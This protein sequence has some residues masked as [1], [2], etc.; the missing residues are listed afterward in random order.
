MQFSD[1][2]NFR[3]NVLLANDIQA[4]RID[5]STMTVYGL[6]AR[7]EAKVQLHPTCRDGRYLKQVRELISS[8][9]L[10]SP[11]GYPIFLRRWSRMGQAKAESLAQL[12][13]LGEPEAVAAVVN[14]PSLT[15]ELARRAWWAESSSQNA[16]GMLA[17]EQ[18]AQS[19]FG[20]ILAKHLIDYLPFEEEPMHIIESVRLVLQADL[21]TPADK[22]A[23]WQKG[24]KK[25]VYLV[26]FLW[27]S[28]DALP[29][30]TPTHP[31]V[32]YFTTQLTPLCTAGN[33]IAQQLI[34]L[35]KNTGQAFLTTAEQVLRKPTHQEVVNILFDIIADYFNTICPDEYG[36]IEI[37]QLLEQ[38]TQFCQNP[39]DNQLGQAVNAVLTEL[40]ESQTLVQAMLV[41]AGLRY[42]LV[43]PIFSRTTAIGSLMRKKLAPVTEPILTQ[44]AILRGV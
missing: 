36:D 21:I 19:D 22:Q 34:R 3:L 37:T 7:G 24:K 31:Q 8:H 5:E 39:P 27:S 14:A 12:L 16:R 6:S 18:I 41:L 13:M 33:P 29:V 11:G 44:F 17:N 30:L 43:R 20:Q 9:V 2:D 25:N 4:I 28:P 1:E 38:A 32:E 40:P 10:G 26:G 35:L 15:A 23:L 42:S